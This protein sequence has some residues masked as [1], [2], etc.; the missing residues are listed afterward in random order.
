VDAGS[1]GSLAHCESSARYRAIAVAGLKLDPTRVRRIR[2][3]LYDGCRA[4]LGF[5]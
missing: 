5:L 3:L 4:A 2:Y 1:R